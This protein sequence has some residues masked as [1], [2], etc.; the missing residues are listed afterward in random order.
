[1]KR[2]ANF[3]DE[4]IDQLCRSWLHVS[5]NAETRTGP[6]LK[7]FGNICVNISMNLGLSSQ[8]CAQR[9]RWKPN[10]SPFRYLSPNFAAVFQIYMD[11]MRVVHQMMKSFAL[12]IFTMGSIFILMRSFGVLS[13]ISIW[14][15]FREK[16]AA[17]TSVKLR[18]ET[19]DS[20]QADRHSQSSTP[21][22]PI[23]NE[24]TKETN[25]FKNSLVQSN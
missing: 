24:E 6:K 15:T 18:L 20:V 7:C 14:Q 3:D 10:G 17:K 8:R 13:V 19:S 25:R 23:G 5:Q 21:A 9:V 11:L 16:H 1:M 22:R 12:Q 4:E 2:V